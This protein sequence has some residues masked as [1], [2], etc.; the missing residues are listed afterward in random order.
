[1]IEEPHDH[2]VGIG[3]SHVILTSV[4]LKFVGL[5]CHPSY[6]N[7]SMLLF[8][9][10]ENSQKKGK[11]TLD[12]HQVEITHTPLSFL[13]QKICAKTKPL[14]IHQV[15]HIC[16]ISCYQN[17]HQLDHIHT[18]SYYQNQHQL[19]HIHT[20][21]NYQ[22]RHQLD[23]IHTILAIKTERL[24]KESERNPPIKKNTVDFNGDSEHI[25][26]PH[27][28]NCLESHLRAEFLTPQLKPLACYVSIVKDRSVFLI[29]TKR[30]SV[31]SQLGF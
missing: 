1:L 27:H 11:K 3:C 18:I 24:N 6:K 20:V 26:I 2:C 31:T 5:T 17:R 10:S 13:V 8:V 19:D 30:K 4:M 28:F 21:S 14:A 16:T 15:D 23:H 29:A 25:S 22:N 9:C 7:R 12:I